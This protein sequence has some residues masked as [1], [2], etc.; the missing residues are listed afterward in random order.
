MC[1]VRLLL[2]LLC[3]SAACSCA[4]RY[5]VYS[6]DR[7]ASGPLAGACSAASSCPTCSSSLSTLWNS[8]LSSWMAST[9]S[10]VAVGQTQS[11]AQHCIT[12]WGTP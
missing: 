7:G 8:S 1:A 12:S 2:R 6:A 3:E 10:L 5:L 9:R 4:S 11:L